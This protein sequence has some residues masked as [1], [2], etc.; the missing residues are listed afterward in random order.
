[1]ILVACSSQETASRNAAQALIRLAG[2]EETGP[3]RYASGAMLLRVVDSSL[4]MAQGLDGEGAELIIFMSRHSSAAGVSAFT[5][6]PMGNWGPQARLGGLAHTLSTAA[7]SPMLGMLR[8][9]ERSRIKMEVTY[10]TTHH[11]P[12]LTTPS[13]FAEFGGNEATVGNPEI[14][15]ELARI[16]YE[17]A[18]RLSDG[19]EGFEHSKVAMG[20]GGT[21][22]PKKFTELALR[23][24]Y[25]FSHMMS[26]H[27][28]L[29]PDGT[30]NIEMLDQA[31]RSSQERVE[32]AVIDWKSISSAARAAAIKKLNEIGIDYER[33]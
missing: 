7:P 13:L 25:A 21:H 11:G 12:A 17:A 15:G 19:K 33:I 30:N 1:M 23:R 26:K 6:H 4:P 8:M 22:Y 18:T 2:L 28:I 14:A 24:G 10:E 5:V 31:A 9:F 16:V 32:A 20:I 27:A 29:N 3:G